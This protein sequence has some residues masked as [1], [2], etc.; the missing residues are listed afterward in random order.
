MG[1]GQRLDPC[2]AYDLEDFLKYEAVDYTEE[3]I[4]NFMNLLRMNTSISR[5][6]RGDIR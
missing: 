4:R 6:G 3:G 5:S 2:H 1:R